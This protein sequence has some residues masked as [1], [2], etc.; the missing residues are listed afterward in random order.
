MTIFGYPP[1]F[2]NV[3]C[4]NVPRKSDILPDRGQIE[5]SPIHN[6]RKRLGRVSSGESVENRELPTA[7]ITLG[8]Y[9]FNNDHCNVNKIMCST[10][11]CI[12]ALYFSQIEVNLSLIC[13][14]NLVSYFYKS[15]GHNL[16]SFCHLRCLILREILPK[17]WQNKRFPPSCC[18]GFATSGLSRID[19]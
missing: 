2:T 17:H 12:L 6:S 11:P 9:N 18:F 10:I 14:L 1:Q 8:N 3:F 7:A 4:A 5:I 19:Y 16:Q 15:S 13:A